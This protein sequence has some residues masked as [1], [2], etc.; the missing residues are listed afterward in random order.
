MARRGVD[1]LLFAG[2][3]GTAR[4]VYTAVGERLPTL[5]IPAGVKIHSAVYAANPDSAGDLAAPSWRAGSPACARR[6]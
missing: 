5:G 1:L 2:G 6:R 4:D 3:D